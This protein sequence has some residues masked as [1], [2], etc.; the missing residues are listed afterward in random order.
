MLCYASKREMR[1]AFKRRGRVGRDFHLKFGRTHFD[2]LARL[3]A[4]VD[5]YVTAFFTIL[6]LENTLAVQTHRHNHSVIVRSHKLSDKIERETLNKSAFSS[7][8]FD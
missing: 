5:I 7:R 1:K 2:F 4:M 3:V 8:N 6:K